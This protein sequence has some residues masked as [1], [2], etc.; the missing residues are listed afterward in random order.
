MLPNA[1]ASDGYFDVAVIDQISVSEVLLNLPKLYNGKIVH[2][3]KMRSIRA[4]SIEI[5]S[6]ETVLLEA[7]GEFLGSTRVQFEIIQ[8]G[9]KIMQT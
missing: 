1:E 5:T 2:H 9:V 4:K 8:H 3:P 6:D 7:D